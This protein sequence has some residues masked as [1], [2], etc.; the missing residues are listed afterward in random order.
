MSVDIPM[1]EVL[2]KRMETHPEEF[3]E[4]IDSRKWGSII[5]RYSECLTQPERD[6]IAQ[7]IRDARRLMMNQAIMKK[8]AGEED[9]VVPVEVPYTFNTTNRA[10]WGTSTTADHE[11]LHKMV[12]ESI[13]RREEELEL[14]AMHDYYKKIGQAE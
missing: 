2:L 8:L 9:P 14:D 3:S 11:A 5:E 6:K 1:L 4:G 7:G 10:V 12:A 13:K